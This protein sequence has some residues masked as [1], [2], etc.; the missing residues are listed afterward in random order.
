MTR[1]QEAERESDAEDPLGKPL[2][3]YGTNS[4][5]FML[6]VT[7]AVLGLSGGVVVVNADWFAL[8]FAESQESTAY[9]FVGWILLV[10]G[11]LTMAWGVWGY[12]RY[13][14]LR[15]KGVRFTRRQGTTELR[16]NEVESILVNKTVTVVRGART[17]NWE[18]SIYGGEESIYL[19]PG[20]LRLVPSV[21]ELLTLLK[22]VSGVEVILPEML[23]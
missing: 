3:R 2:A 22:A 16:W 5:A 19:S 14:E 4:K 6:M 1:K 23:Y 15:R 17:V 20:F 12:G 10:L 21:S 7:A 18:I 9:R 8:R 11:M 13:F